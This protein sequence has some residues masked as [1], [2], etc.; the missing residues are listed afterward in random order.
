MKTVEQK[1]K[2]EISVLGEV[3]I[4]IIGPALLPRAL[5]VRCWEIV[6]KARF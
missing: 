6:R 1:Y 3:I 4:T 5:G 2:V